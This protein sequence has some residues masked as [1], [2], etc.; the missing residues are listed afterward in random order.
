MMIDELSTIFPKIRGAYLVGGS[1]RDHLL[2]KAPVDYDLVV[3]ENPGEYGR[4]IAS[5]MPGHLVELGKPGQTIVRV[6]SRKISVDISAIEG[7][8]IAEDLQRRDFS[9]NAMA[10]ELASGKFI[11]DVGGQRDLAHKVIRMLTPRAFVSDP[12]RLLRAF[13]LAAGLEFTIE[14]A[15]LA[16]I[17]QHAGLIRK[18]AGERIKDEL[19]KMLQSDSSHPFLLQMAESGLFRQLFPELFRVKEDP[20]KPN[21][22]RPVIEDTF[23]AYG[24]LE[25]LL[26]DPAQHLPPGL[27]PHYQEFTDTVKALLKFSI[28]WHSIG[29]PAVDGQ[30]TDEC[31]DANAARSAEMAQ[32]LCR[33]YRF[34]NRHTEYIQF[35]IKNQTRPF[36][37]FSVS[38]N[39]TL[40]REDTTRF[41]MECRAQTPELMLHALAEMYAQQGKN[42]PRGRAFL[43]LL[44]HLLQDGYNTF[45]AKAASPPLITGR[46]L[47]A[48]FELVPSPLFKEILHSIE[49]ARLSGKARTRSD[50]L[51]MAKKILAGHARTE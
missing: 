10:Y 1:I 13:R 25:D 14:P 26:K 39:R 27:E 20:V 33:R 32:Q 8:T 30:N 40:T 23:A 37:L 41:F 4:R 12:L 51:R 42:S 44:I 35:I 45:K 49:E 16:A 31:N 28:L 36:S 3:S 7:K 47:I 46:D 5:T 9:I 34:S 43:N 22:N 29:G 50:A 11:D 17:A 48:E 24:Q 18:S 6:V 2:G 19:F 15:T 21:H 38:Q